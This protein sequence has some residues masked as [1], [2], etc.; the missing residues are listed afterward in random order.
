MQQNADEL[1]WCQLFLDKRGEWGRYRLRY[2]VLFPS[3]SRSGWQVDV[4]RVS[5]SGPAVRDDAD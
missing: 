5:R 4:A 2:A 3:S 1:A